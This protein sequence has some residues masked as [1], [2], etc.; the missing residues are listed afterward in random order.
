MPGPGSRAAPQQRPNRRRATEA[1]KDNT[2]ACGGEPSHRGRA[3]GAVLPAA[4]H[5]RPMR[6]PCG[7]SG[8]SATSAPARRCSSSDSTGR[9][10]RSV[11]GE[12]KRLLPKPRVRRVV[13]DA[14]EGRRALR[15][16]RRTGSQERRKY[17][18]WATSSAVTGAPARAQPALLGSNVASAAPARNRAAGEAFASSST[19]HRSAV[20]ASRE[21][22]NTRTI[23][24]WSVASAFRS[25]SC[26]G[27]R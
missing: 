5:P 27:R 16:R 17:G 4:H 21:G 13:K 8:H 9:L 19:R 14:D 6:S 1:K 26:K 2:R 25:A 23:S 3:V 12:G 7:M 15:T 11:V 22:L 18:S 24:P 10:I 20:T